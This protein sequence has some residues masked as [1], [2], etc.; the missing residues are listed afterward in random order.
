MMTTTCFC[1]VCGAANE[2]E[3]THCFACG[4]FLVRGIND[5]EVPQEVLLCGRYQL[6]TL[7]GSGGFSMVYHARDMQAGGREVAI[8]QIRLQGLSA[9]E[10]IEA[11]DT[12]NREVSLL[13]ILHHPQIPQLYEHFYDRDHWYLVLEYLEGTTLEVYL[14]KCAA[15]SRSIQLDEALP[16]ALQLCTVLEYLHTRQPPIIFRDLKPGNI[17]RTPGGKLC[18]I[19][20]G[21]ARRFRPG[22]VRDTQRLGSPGYA[23]PEQY[24]RA[25][26]T[27][28]ADIYSLGAL[29]HAL[30]SG[31]DPSTQT[32]GL[33]PLQPDGYA[34]EADLVALVQRMLSSDPAKRPARA[35]EVAAVLEQV[36]SRQLVKHS[37]QRVWIPPTPQ[38]YSPT[39]ARQQQQMQIH[40]QPS[41]GQNTSSVAKPRTRRRAV[42]IGLGT[43]AVAMAGGSVAW[44]ALTTPAV[45]SSEPQ[46]ASAHQPVP[47]YTYHGH[48]GGVWNAVWSPDGA[49]VASCSQ[50]RTVQIWDALSGTNAFIYNGHAAAVNDATWSPNGN[51]IASASD[52]GT[53]HVWDPFK[54]KNAL[55]YSGHRASV[56]EANW[57]PDGKRIASCSGDKTV[58]VWHAT[59]GKLIN[60]YQEHTQEVLAVK[61][62]P[63]GKYIAS[64]SQD[65]TVRVW[66]AATALTIF[67]YLGHK[68]DVNEIAWS[69]D[70]ERIASASSDQTARVWNALDGSNALIYTGHKTDVNTVA[71]S[72]DGQKI[73]SGDGSGV[74]QIWD[75]LSTTAIFTYPGDSRA[76]IEVNWSPNGALLASASED[77]TVRIWLTAS[78]PG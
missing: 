70:G 5:T 49:R 14:E 59:T 52:D 71:W 26:T 11:T 28:Q 46:P 18:L 29:L 10:T 30:L 65:E 17:I 43:L 56:V 12:F 55:I 37:S 23:A 67:T 48:S 41:A 61:W 44:Q 31:Q 73:A 22:Q 13:S 77:M 35:R 32:Q 38:M 40:I 72:P 64:S 42:L 39:L 50:D 25:Q 74:V 16:M 76:I 78:V 51:Y 7:L 75:A 15:Q 20:F 4:Q 8:K 3:S 60:M 2:L 19:D 57:S 68:G 1:P 45:S 36:Q 62:S 34:D 53:V 9:E 27:P 58:H 66:E 6:G 33:T 63:D 47:F 24:G 54:G 21:I 69:P